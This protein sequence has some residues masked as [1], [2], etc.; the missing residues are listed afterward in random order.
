MVFAG[1]I[2]L[3]IS[4]IILDLGWALNPMI[5]GLIRETQSEISDTETYREESH[6]KLE[7]EIR[8]CSN[9]LCNTWSHQ[10]LEEARKGSP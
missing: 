4:E 3:R 2:K 10:K 8:V 5:D 6:V 9:E 1:G 7:A